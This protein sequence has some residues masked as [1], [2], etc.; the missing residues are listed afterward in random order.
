MT[1]VIY[2]EPHPKG[3]LLTDHLDVP[4]EALERLCAHYGVRIDNVGIGALLRQ[5]R[6][7]DQNLAEAFES[8]YI[9]KIEAE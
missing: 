5:M 4:P 1:R 8:L 6:T 2:D 9:N 3:F 7:E